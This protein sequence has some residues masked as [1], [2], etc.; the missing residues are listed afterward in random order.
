LTKHGVI[1]KDNSLVYFLNVLRFFR[2]VLLQDVAAIAATKQTDL[3][4]LQYPPFNTPAFLNF[5]RSAGSIIEQAENSNRENLRNIPQQLAQTFAGQLTAVNIQQKL[6][7]RRLLEL[8]LDN[9]ARW[10]EFLDSSKS[11]KK[12]KAASQSIPGM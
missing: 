2:L 6:H 11:S 4:I 7:D 5:A 12:R 1:A 8:Q 9:A 10:A 3:S